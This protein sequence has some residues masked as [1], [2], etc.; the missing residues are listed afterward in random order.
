[1]TIH[2][3]QGSEYDDVILV[4]PEYCAQFS[5][6]KLLYTGMSRAKKKL[7]II[8]S[9]ETVEAIINKKTR[10]KRNTNLTWNIR[11]DFV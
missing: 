8:G 11:T 2:K 6:K 5:E 7:T 9:E 4:L 10:N 3:S 1:L